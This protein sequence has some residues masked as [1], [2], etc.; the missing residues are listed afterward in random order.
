M[1]KIEIWEDC[2]VPD[3]WFE[4]R[5]E[6]ENPWGVVKKIE[7]SLENYFQISAAGHGNYMLKWD[8]SG[9]PI[10]FLSRWWVKKKFSKWSTFMLSIIVDGSIKKSDRSGRF[11]MRFKASLKTEYKGFWI[12]AKPFWIIYSYL[13]YNRL[14]RN[15]LERC[16]ELALG[17][18]D[19]VK[20][21]YDMKVISQY[22]F[23][24]IAR[25]G[26]LG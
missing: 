8:N 16:Q 2:L 13:F 20:K 18:R 22:K 4:L 24:P 6:G 11:N 12:F 7:N 9:D 23:A 3:R 14:R 19:L 25:K 15:F 21:E 26:G 1:G 17:F 10:N 5:Y